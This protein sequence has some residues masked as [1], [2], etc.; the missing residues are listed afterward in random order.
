[1]GSV[2]QKDPSHQ[3]AWLSSPCRAWGPTQPNF[4]NLPKHQRVSHPWHSPATSYHRVPDECGER[5]SME[6]RTVEKEEGV[7]RK[8]ERGHSLRVCK[9][10]KSPCSFFQGGACPCYHRLPFLPQRL[11]SSCSARRPLHP[12]PSSR[13]VLPNR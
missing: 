1:M 13:Y 12:P 4:S 5:V 6:F 11:D 2:S 3:V 7:R 8:T 10:H 9:E